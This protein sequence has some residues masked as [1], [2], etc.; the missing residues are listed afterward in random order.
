MRQ[1]TKRRQEK[2]ITLSGRC[3][4]NSEELVYELMNMG[5]CTY[6]WQ[7]NNEAQALARALTHTYTLIPRKRNEKK[8]RAQANELC[9]R[10]IVCIRFA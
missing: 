3:Q 8:S 2:N 7:D 4:R 9:T 6:F 1:N 5:L 10:F